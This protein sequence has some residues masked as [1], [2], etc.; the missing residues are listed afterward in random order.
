MILV[1]HLKCVIH[2]IG[3]YIKK[4]RITAQQQGIA[5]WKNVY[6]MDVQ[7]VKFMSVL[8]AV[9]LIKY[10]VKATEDNFPE[11]AG[12]IVMINAPPVAEKCWL[13][14]KPFLDKSL[15]EKFKFFQGV[16]YDYL[17][18]LMDKSVLFEEY[19]GTNK[20]DFPH[21]ITYRSK[22]D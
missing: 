22:D 10:C 5:N 7:N 2:E 15:I 20:T 18:T 4:F 8:R 19:G 6:I 12:P 1:D 16:P 3:E 13:L 14:V 9:S 21:A 11:M 17:L